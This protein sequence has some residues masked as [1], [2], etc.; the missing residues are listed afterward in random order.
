MLFRSAAKSGI[1][2]LGYDEEV[3]LESIVM[4][5]Q[6]LLYRV[7]LVRDIVISYSIAVAFF[8]LASIFIGVEFLA[9]DVNMQSL[10]L[11][12]FVLGV[13][14]VLVGI[15]LAAFETKKGYDIVKIEV[16]AEE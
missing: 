1:K 3:R 4:Q 5:M 12:F 7:R 10:A 8:V 2:D 6:K 9:K 15:L 16:K 14:L 13:F 11:V